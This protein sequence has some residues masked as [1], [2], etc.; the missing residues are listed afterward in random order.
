MRAI[1]AG[2]ELK[3]RWGNTICEDDKHQWA[4]DG[5]GSALEEDENR[6][7]IRYF[8]VGFKR[9]TICGITKMYDPAKESYAIFFKDIRTQHIEIIE[10]DI[11]AGGEICDHEWYHVRYLEGKTRELTTPGVGFM[12]PVGEK[13]CYNCGRTVIYDATKEFLRPIDTH[14][15][16]P[17]WVT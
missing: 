4:H 2:S 15:G 12:Y 9:C 5:F 10:D 7:V 16:E 11:P 8:P 1:L 3:Y 14:R 6:K 17:G 13:R